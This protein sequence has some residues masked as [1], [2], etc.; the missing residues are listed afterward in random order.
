MMILIRRPSLALFAILA[1]LGAC[2]D[3]QYEKHVAAQKGL[4]PADQFAT[5]GRE[6]AIAMAIGREFARPW[7]SGAETQADVVIAYARNKFGKDI[8]DI[9][10]DPLGHR[11]VVTFASGWRTAIVPIDDGK[12]GDETTIPS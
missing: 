1:L 7:N 6:Q 10:A 11:I 9:S 3:Y 8:S 4:I 12:T 2:R 5:Y